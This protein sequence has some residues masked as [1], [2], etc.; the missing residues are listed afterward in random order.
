MGFLSGFSKVGFVGNYGLI[1]EFDSFVFIFTVIIWAS[2]GIV[3]KQS[4]KDSI[5]TS[6]ANLTY[7]IL[8]LTSIL[9]VFRIVI[10]VFRQLKR[11]LGSSGISEIS[12]MNPMK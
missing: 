6:T 4:T 11:P 12:E 10:V 7:T 2:I 9:L 5:P 1:H 8:G 3:T